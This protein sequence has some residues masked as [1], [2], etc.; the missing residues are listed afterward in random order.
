MSAFQKYPYNKPIDYFCFYK[1]HKSGRTVSLLD[2]K[3]TVCRSFSNFVKNKVHVKWIKPSRHRTLTT[4]KAQNKIS[5]QVLSM[6]WWTSFGAPSNYPATNS[7]FKLSP[8]ILNFIYTKRME[9]K[10]KKKVGWQRWNVANCCR[11]KCMQNDKSWKNSTHSPPLSQ[12]WDHTAH[13]SA[14]I[15][16]QAALVTLPSCDQA[17]YTL[18]RPPLLVG[19]LQLPSHD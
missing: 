3:L 4:R 17:Q 6:F 7:A 16:Y 10:K 5:E 13:I 9:G 18:L 14:T 11:P 12:R 19:V 1:T 2:A 8:F 15:A